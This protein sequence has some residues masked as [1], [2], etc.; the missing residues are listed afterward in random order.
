MTELPEFAVVKTTDG[1][2]LIE[3]KHEGFE[4]KTFTKEQADE[5]IRRCKGYKE[6][7]KANS[8]YLKR[9]GDVAEQLLLWAKQSKEGGWSKH[10][11]EPMMLLADSIYILIGKT[12][13]PEIVKALEE[14]K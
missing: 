3:P 6:V 8:N 4:L 9:L 11:V 2:C 5:I 13:K 10:Q 12:C 1:G 14:T 7:S